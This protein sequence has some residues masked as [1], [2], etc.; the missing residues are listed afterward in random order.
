MPTYI[1]LVKMT[2]SGKR[3]IAGSLER[4]EIVA[5]ARERLG[6]SM[7]Y[8]MTLGAYDFVLIFVAPTEQAMAELLL[9]IGQIGA[10]HTE[11]M[12][13]LGP[14]DYDPLLRKLAA[15]T[16]KNQSTHKTKEREEDE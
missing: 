11:T 16:R 12:I 7:Q 1:S 9:F 2:A 6:I 10:I 4:G 14:Q 5:E 8:Y 3:E 15:E 13:A